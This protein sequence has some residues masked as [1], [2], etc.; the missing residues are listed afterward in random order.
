MI[1]ENLKRCGEVFVALSEE[2]PYPTVCNKNGGPFIVTFDPIDGNNILENNSA[3]GSIFGIWPKMYS[4]HH[5][6]FANIGICKV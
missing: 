6:Y 1:F 2:R 4:D 3:I 5:S